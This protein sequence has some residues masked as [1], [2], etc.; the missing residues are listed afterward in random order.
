MSD[1]SP[2]PQAEQA[3]AVATPHVP[4][5]HVRQVSAAPPRKQ[6]HQA[7][8]DLW[9]SQASLDPPPCPHASLDANQRKGALLPASLSPGLARATEFSSFAEF[10]S[11]ADFSSSSKFSS[12][13]EFSTS[14][15]FPSAP[16]FSSWYGAPARGLN[17]TCS[18]NQPAGGV[19]KAC[20][21]GP[22]GDHWWGGYEDALFE[23]HVLAF[24][25][26]H[27]PDTPMFL[28]WAPH[29]VHAPLQV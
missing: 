1:V 25:H 4:A 3:A 20:R 27:D 28:F 19:R 9:L 13:S 24:I 23:Q 15:D 16:E 29:I 6:V 10:T 17:N 12:S 7:V 5:T 26:K 21:P 22:R 8:V 11:S 18:G 14:T 2:D